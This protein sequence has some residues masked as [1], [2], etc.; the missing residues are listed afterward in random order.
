MIEA[1]RPELTIV[2]PAFNE[3]QRLPAT[4]AAIDRY[5]VDERIVAEIIV[6]DDGSTDGTADIAR[7]FTPSSADLVVLSLPHRGKAYAVRDGILSATADYVLFTDADLSTPMRFAPL[8][9]DELRRGAGVAIG[10]REGI[11]ARRVG[12]PAYRHFMGR[13]FNFV[14][15]ALAVPGIS[16]TQCG[17]KAFR[18]DAARKIFARTQ[19]HDPGEIRGPRV[20]GFDVEV[21]F[22]ARRLGYRIATVPVYWEHV[23]GSKVRPIQDSALMF[24]DVVRVRVNALRGRYDTTARP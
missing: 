6:A 1:Q 3:E 5:L 17:F 9:L 4:L 12:E 19:L 2:I 18:A 13:V 15:Q 21:L 11:G 24:L 23:P 10:S 14:V 8:L 16:D 7:R 22:I 20:S